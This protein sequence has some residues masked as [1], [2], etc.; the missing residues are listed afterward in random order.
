MLRTLPLFA[1][2]LIACSTPPVVGDPE[3]GPCTEIY[4]PLRDEDRTPFGVR[5]NQLRVQLSGTRQGTTGDGAMIS[6]V[7]IWDGG[8]AR[9]LWTERDES[10]EAPDPRPPMWCEDRVEV[11]ARF[12]V[13]VEGAPVELAGVV[14]AVGPIGDLRAAFRAEAEAGRLWV[15]ASE[16]RG[17]LQLAGEDPVSF[18]LD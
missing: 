11:P 7:P 1:T 3:P 15:W 14:A 4:D 13:D 9:Q 12:R 10:F 17:E 2:S 18:T 6:I 16:D 5:P 8:L